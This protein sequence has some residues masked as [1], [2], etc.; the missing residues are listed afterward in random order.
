VNKIQYHN[1]AKVSYLLDNN[2]VHIFQI[3]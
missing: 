3:L 1:G 2:N